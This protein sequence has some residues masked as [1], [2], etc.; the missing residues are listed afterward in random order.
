MR[1]LC[2]KVRWIS[3][4]HEILNGTV[5]GDSKRNY[6]VREFIQNY[7]NKTLWNYNQLGEY[8]APVSFMTSSSAL[9]MQDIFI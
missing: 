3:V 5:K 8:Y 2:E 4:K 6:E 1:R 7:L 9:I